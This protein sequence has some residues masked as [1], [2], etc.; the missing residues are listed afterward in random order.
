[1]KHRFTDYSIT[2]THVVVKEFFWSQNSPL[3]AL[4]IELCQFDQLYL[5]AI[6]KPNIRSNK[7]SLFLDKLNEWIIANKKFK[8]QEVFIVLDFW[9]I[10]KSK[11]VVQKL[12]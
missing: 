7:F 5:F 1:M 8:K 6:D 11:E 9:S 12:Q 2:L 4:S 3:L 10:H